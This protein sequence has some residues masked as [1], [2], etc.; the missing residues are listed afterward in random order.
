MVEGEESFRLSSCLRNI[1]NFSSMTTFDPFDSHPTFQYSGTTRAVYPL[2]KSNSKADIPSSIVKPNYAREGVRNQ[3]EYWWQVGRSLLFSFVSSVVLFSHLLLFLLFSR[4]Q[5]FSSKNI[6]VNNELEQEGVRKAAIVSKS[7]CYASLSLPT[8]S[9]SHLSLFSF[10]IQ[11]AREVLTITASHIKPGISTNELDEICFKE[12]IKRDCYPSPLDY[13]GFPKSICTSVNEVICHGIPDGTILKD[14]DSINLGKSNLSPTKNKDWKPLHSES[15]V[16]LT[17]FVL[18]LL[19]LFSDVTLYHH[20]ES[21]LEVP[22]F[23]SR[24]AGFSPMSKFI[25]SY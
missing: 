3:L 7:F 13:H 23:L 2:D 24:E 10:S 1:L 11:L 4:Y 8:H 22:F 6:K 14:G 16:T 21:H 5:L 25:D 17:L 20:G 18:L 9:H 19:C 15:L 12:A